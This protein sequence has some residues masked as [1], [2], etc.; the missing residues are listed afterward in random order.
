M[1]NIKSI[2]ISPTYIVLKVGDWYHSATAQVFPNAIN[3]ATVT[4]NSSNKTIATV[5]P[6]NG[7]VYAHNP[8]VAIITASL[9]TEENV[10]ACYTVVV[11]N[12][13]Q[14]QGENTARKEIT[15]NADIKVLATR[16]DCGSYSD[17]AFGYS[18]KIYSYTLSGNTA[19]LKKGIL[20][21]TKSYNYYAA[22]FQSAVHDMAVIYNSFSPLQRQA[23]LI[24]RGY[25]LLTSYS[26]SAIDAI[27]LLAGV[28]LQGMLESTVLGM[29]AWY[30][31][32]EQA[33]SCFSQF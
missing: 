17:M 4:W 15:A 14:I 21:K 3:Q 12:K 18:G 26:M 7:Y 32:E 16:S 22:L 8:G 20:S 24:L 31:A 29:N 25:G 19:T 1:N 27:L 6:I 28:D 23:W 9:N 11:E 33:S 10:N 5:N 30:R 13:N 2:Q